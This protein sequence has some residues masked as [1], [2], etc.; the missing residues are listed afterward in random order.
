VEHS[1][2]RS[3]NPRAPGEIRASTILCLHTGHIGRSPIASP[4]SL[5]RDHRQPDLSFFHYVTS[6]SVFKWRLG[7]WDGRASRLI[8]RPAEMRGLRG[9]R[10]QPPKPPKAGLRSG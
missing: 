8:Q 7:A 10:P 5:P 4:I 3:S 9:L 1:N 2:V 6:G